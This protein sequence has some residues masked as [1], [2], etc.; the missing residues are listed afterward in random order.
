MCVCVCV[1]VYVRV[2]VWFLSACVCA[3]V[4]VCGVVSRKS[5]K[6][7]KEVQHGAPKRAGEKNPPSTE[8]I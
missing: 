5:E 1:C 3:C 4:R 7:D 6:R 2:C 8:T